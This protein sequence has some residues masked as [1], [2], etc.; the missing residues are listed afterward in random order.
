VQIEAE[1]VVRSWRVRIIRLVAWRKVSKYAAESRS[2]YPRL[3]QSHVDLHQEA[4]L[5]PSLLELLQRT[6]TCPAG[7]TTAVLGVCVGVCVVRSVKAEASALMLVG[8]IVRDIVG[9]CAVAVACHYMTLDV[10]V[11]LIGKGQETLLQDGWWLM[12]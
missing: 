7:C 10:R 8:H 2:I 1:L 3:L 4:T 6:K 11:V 9:C 12:I 5:E